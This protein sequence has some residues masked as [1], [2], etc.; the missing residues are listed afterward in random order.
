[1]VIFMTAL[2]SIARIF[3]PVTVFI[4]D[5]LPASMLT[6]HPCVCMIQYVAPSGEEVYLNVMM[7]HEFWKDA[8]IPVL[9]MADE[10]FDPL[11]YLFILY[12]LYG[13]ILNGAA[14]FGLRGLLYCISLL[15]NR[16]VG[17]QDGGQQED[18]KK[19]K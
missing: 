14:T 12:F 4:Y 15:L 2:W 13:T 11:Y 19:Q 1:M 10:W 8:K 9:H 17:K 3:I 5:V 16:L 18:A 7:G 6:G